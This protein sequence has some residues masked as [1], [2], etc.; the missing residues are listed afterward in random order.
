MI[1]SG[2]NYVNRTSYN[3]K[4]S[5]EKK[6]INVKQTGVSEENNVTGYHLR[7]GSS[8]NEA[9]AATGF[10]DGSSLSVFKAEEYSDEEPVMLVKYWD[11]DGTLQESKVNAKEIKPD[12]ATYIEMFALS[13]YYNEKGISKDSVETFMTSNIGL[14]GT[15]KEQSYDTITAKR[16]FMDQIKE[17][18]QMQYNNGN[19][20][21]YQQFSKYYGLLGDL[22]TKK[23]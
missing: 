3:Y 8:G 14:D 21:G 16:N 10:A 2:L 15:V 11:K 18:G 13:A 12:N 4:N 6:N 22:L 1:I 17:W 5:T 9:I 7:I 23:G 19:L 20:A